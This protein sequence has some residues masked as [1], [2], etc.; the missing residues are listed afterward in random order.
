[1]IVWIILTVM[2]SVAAVGVTIPLVRHYDARRARAGTL[3]VLKDQL[4][5]IDAQAAAQTLAP[6]DAEVLRAETARRILAEGARAEPGARPLGGRALLVLGLGLAASIA[7]AA[8]VL[9]SKIGR[10]DLASSPSPAAVVSADGA[11]ADHPEGGDIAGMIGQL[12]TKLARSPGDPEGWRMLGWSYMRTGRYAQA[13]NAYGRAAALDPANAEYLSA[14]GEA[15]TQASAGEVTPAALEAFRLALARDPADPR[16][17]YFLAMA[18][19]QRGDHAGAMADW[20]ALL[21]SAPPDAPWA[22]QVRGLVEGIARAHGEDISGRLPPTPAPT[23]ADAAQGPVS[24]AP[25]GPTADQVAAAGAMA[26]ADQAA[27][28]RGMVEGLASRLKTNPRNPDGWL[29]LMRAR[30]VLGQPGDAASAYHQAL[31]AY[32]DSPAQRAA[33]RAAAAQLEIPG[34]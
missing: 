23:A 27:M 4:G 20:I 32:A 24:A 3:G 26:P 21:K 9:Y 34:A 12:E 8:T 7:V 33:F 16:A 30:M 29:R 18:R 10:P 22:A 19:D 13:A 1:M 11:D 17:R 14:Q 28:I 5:D 2:I 31:S 6:T 15:L 25:V